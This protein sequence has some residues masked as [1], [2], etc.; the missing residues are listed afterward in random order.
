MALKWQ[1]TLPATSSP[2]EPRDGA[3]RQQRLN[4]IIPNV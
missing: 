1:V 4:G 3:M 2:I